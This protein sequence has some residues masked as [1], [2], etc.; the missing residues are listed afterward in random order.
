MNY[1]IGTDLGSTTSKSIVMDENERIVG[2]GL[3]NTR[4]NYE[5]A[6]KVAEQEALIGAR[7]TFLGEE[8]RHELNLSEER[9]NDLI[10]KH[11][12]LFRYEHYYD[13]VVLLHEKMEEEIESAPSSEKKELKNI[14]QEIFVELEKNAFDY[15]QEAG[16]DK[17]TFFRDLIGA[18]YMKLAEQANTYFETMMSMFDKSIMIV[19]NHMPEINIEKLGRKSLDKLFQIEQLE[20][21]KS[22]VDKAFQIASTRKI[23]I[24]CKVGTGYG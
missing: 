6:T 21:L 7:F 9:I 1:F 20:Q 22:K 2:R 24:A 18:Q 11:E 5:V 14:V 23:N 16:K 19:E 4:S 13:N 8:L 12:F 17:S 15:Y 3:T 10:E